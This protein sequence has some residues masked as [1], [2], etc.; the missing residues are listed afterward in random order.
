MSAAGTLAT[1]DPDKI[2]LN[3]YSTSCGKFNA[4]PNT[5]TL[6]QS[7]YIFVVSSS[8]G[9]SSGYQH[10]PSS[11]CGPSSH[12]EVKIQ[13]LPLIDWL[14]SPTNL[15]RPLLTFW[16]NWRKD[17]PCSN[18]NKLKFN[19]KKS[20]FLKGP[21]AIFPETPVFFCLNCW[22]APH[23]AFS[24]FPFPHAQSLLLSHTQHF[25]DT[26]VF[27]FPAN[28]RVLPSTPKSIQGFS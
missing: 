3:L 22:A 26:W 13:S 11:A 8:S 23:T 24:S 1:W 4:L 5:S 7:C 20:L 14:T 10:S 28:F 17:L 19:S 2:G 16:G 15:K 21:S 18:A 25:S 6:S 12:P 27:S 9:I